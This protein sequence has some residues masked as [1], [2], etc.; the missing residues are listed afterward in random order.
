VFFLTQKKLFF[1]GFFLGLPQIYPKFLGQPW[2]NPKNPRFF[3]G[4]PRVA[5]EIWVEMFNAH[6][7][8][9]I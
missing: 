5:P 2:G 4:Y 9:Y 7:Q 8:G 6:L 3:W 1:W